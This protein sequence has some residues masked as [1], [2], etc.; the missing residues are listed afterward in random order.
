[1][2]TALA[3]ASTTKLLLLV[4]LCAFLCLVA[5]SLGWWCV[6]IEDVMMFA[7]GMKWLFSA[8]CL[9]VCLVELVAFRHW[10]QSWALLPEA[11]C[12]VVFTLGVFIAGYAGVS[13]CV[14]VV[15]HVVLVRYHSRGQ[16]LENARTTDEATKAIHRWRYL[17]VVLCRLRRLDLDDVVSEVCYPSNIADP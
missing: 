8:S 11:V 13:C 4:V 6:R 15:L 7:A 3:I 16:K 12:I 10:L 14:A 2:L 5:F 9:A 17:H 1:M